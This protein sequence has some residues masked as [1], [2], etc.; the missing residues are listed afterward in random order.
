MRTMTIVQVVWQGIAFLFNVN[1]MLFH[2]PK[3]PVSLLLD[4]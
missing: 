3:G 1:W 4:S 2:S